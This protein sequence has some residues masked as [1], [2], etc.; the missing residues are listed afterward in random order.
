M[1]GISAYTL[2][3]ILLLSMIV[4]C[5]TGEQPVVQVPEEQPVPMQAQQRP[6]AP[7]SASV[8]DIT[9]LTD[10]G[11]NISGT[12][13]PGTG[14]DAVILLHMLGRDRSS[15]EKLPQVLNS[16]GFGVL[17]IDLRGHGKSTQGTY[18]FKAFSAAEFKNMVYD[19][20]GAKQ[21]VKKRGVTGDIA[22]IGASIGANLALAYAAQDK[23]IQDIILLSPG[24]DYRGIGTFVP[25]EQYRGSMLLV[26][27]QDDAR[28]YA[29]TEQL[30]KR[31]NGPHSFHSY[32]DAG[33]GTDML[34]EAD[35]IP[36]ITGWVKDKR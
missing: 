4:G 29:D 7:S 14:Q 23:D 1:K 33:H 17:A 15:W 22:I 2:G 36:T 20:K 24:Q 30:S 9:Y 10:D 19:V 35:L 28:S 25:N 12:Y 5:S 16:E 3:I 11:M 8:Q 6:A 26:A 34:K 21:F 13:Y 31:A 18:D 27:S 32:P